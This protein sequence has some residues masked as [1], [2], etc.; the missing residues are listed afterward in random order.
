M[1]APT[2]APAPE[3]KIKWLR[4]Q[5]RLN[6]AAPGAPAPTPAPQA[7]MQVQPLGYSFNQIATVHIISLT[8]FIVTAVRVN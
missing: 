8:R 3:E 7:C 2:P 5:L 4:L 6:H 1:T